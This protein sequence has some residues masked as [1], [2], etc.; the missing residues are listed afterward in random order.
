ME[1]AVSKQLI[2]A[3][4]IFR[5]ATNLIEA[6]LGAEILLLKFPNLSQVR[7][8]R[9][10]VCVVFDK[11]GGVKSFDSF[12]AA[13][14]RASVQEEASLRL[15]LAGARLVCAQ[16][17]TP[18]FGHVELLSGLVRAMLAHEQCTLLAV[19]VM[20]GLGAVLEGHLELEEQVRLAVMPLLLAAFARPAQQLMGLLVAFFHRFPHLVQDERV[21]K[22]VEE[23]VARQKTPLFGARDPDR[24]IA[25]LDLKGGDIDG[26]KM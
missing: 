1:D 9:L 21:R 8:M 18:R 20:E 4:S 7:K 13:V 24:Y 19:A 6:A 22:S 23:Q 3:V 25:K 26:I 11:D 15:Q 12:V 17:R 5:P 10:M 14:G 2:E 16:A